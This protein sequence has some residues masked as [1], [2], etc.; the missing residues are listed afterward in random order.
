MTSASAINLLHCCCKN[1]EK[2]GTRMRQLLS[3][4]ISSAENQA[5]RGGLQD[6]SVFLG[7]LLNV[8][9]GRP[10]RLLHV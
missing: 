10:H 1:V 7:E 2:G 5:M 4:K 3:Q 6:L 8:F 9:L